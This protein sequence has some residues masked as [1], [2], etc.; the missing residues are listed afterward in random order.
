[1][2]LISSQD[3]QTL[4]ALFTER[5]SNDVNLVYFTQHESKLTVPG[6]ECDFC[7][8]TRELLEELGGLS[9]RLHLEVKDFVGDAGEAQRR[10]IDRIP[11][12]SLEGRAKGKVRFFGIPAG[13]EF[14]T[15][16]EDVLDVGAGTTDLSEASRAALAQITEPVHIK[17]FV[18]PT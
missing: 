18:T 6:Q 7:G 16:V 5:L 14:S 9:E 12:I 1:M 8:K 4:S 13:Y 15:V 11:A 17:V 2:A 3:T 10:G